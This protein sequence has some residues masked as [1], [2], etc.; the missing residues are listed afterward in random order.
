MLANEGTLKEK[1]TPTPHIHI[2]RT[3]PYWLASCPT[4]THDGAIK[5][6]HKFITK[7][8]DNCEMAIAR[9]NF[10]YVEKWLTNG[11][12]NHKLSNQLWKDRKYQMPKSPKH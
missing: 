12:I 3:T 10:P 1:S 2:A 11:Q 4:A 7:E 9:R 6:I 8:H 5:N